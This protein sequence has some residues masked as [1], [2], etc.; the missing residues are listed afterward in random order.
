M[1]GQSQPVCILRHLPSG[2]LA[3]LFNKSS[4]NATKRH[5]LGQKLRSVLAI[6]AQRSSQST[7][8]DAQ[9]IVACPIMLSYGPLGDDRQVADGKEGREKTT[10]FSQTSSSFA[11]QNPP[12]V[13]LRTSQNPL[14][15]SSPEGAD[16]TNVCCLVLCPRVCFEKNGGNSLVCLIANSHY[17]RFCRANENHRHTHPLMS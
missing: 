1:L 3:V 9:R 17:Q 6:E 16:L 11:S 7:S 15:E 13:G 2:I 4:A 14:P 12:W 10:A 8:M 5:R